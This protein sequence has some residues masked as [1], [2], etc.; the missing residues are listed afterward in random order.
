LLVITG[1]AA[2]ENVAWRVFPLAPLTFAVNWIVGVVRTTVTS[3]SL[4][5]SVPVR[6]NVTV[7]TPPRPARD[8]LGS[9]SPTEIELYVSREMTE[10]DLLT[11][12]RSAVPPALF[13]KFAATTPSAGFFTAWTESVLLRIVV[14]GLYAY[15]ATS[16]GVIAGNKV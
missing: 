7:I 9:E 16:L 4:E 1:A 3:A 11:A 12:R 8:W 10:Q 14:C 5:E 13:Q 6:F 15:P 2:S